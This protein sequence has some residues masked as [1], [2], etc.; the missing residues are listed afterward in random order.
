MRVV[1]GNVDEWLNDLET[2]L[3]HGEVVGKQVRAQVS[4]VPL[5]PE[6]VSFDVQFRACYVRQTSDIAY[7]V[8]VRVSLG[9]V[10]GE[11]TEARDRAK[12]YLDELQQLADK[13]E[14]ELRPGV[15][16]L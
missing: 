16:E 1:H 13:H 6:A 15:M 8:E 2:D 11:K 10:Y 9:E 4:E 14:A 3:E 7:P 5:Q 12:A